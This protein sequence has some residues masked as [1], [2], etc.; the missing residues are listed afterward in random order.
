MLGLTWNVKIAK[1]IIFV[2]MNY[3]VISNYRRLAVSPSRKSFRFVPV[4]RAVWLPSGNRT[5]MM[6]P[7]SLFPFGAPTVSLFPFGAPNFP[8][9][10]PPTT[11]PLVQ[12]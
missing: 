9:C 11:K 3:E 6:P 1:P 8:L 12:L 4:V 10:L 7:T 2:E 5:Q